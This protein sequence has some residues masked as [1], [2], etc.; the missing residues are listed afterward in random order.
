MVWLVALPVFLLRRFQH[1]THDRAK[2]M[3]KLQEIAE[4]PMVQRLWLFN[5]GDLACP[6]LIENH[7]ISKWL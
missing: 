2:N 7:E 1:C 4:A 6:K 5:Y 3:S